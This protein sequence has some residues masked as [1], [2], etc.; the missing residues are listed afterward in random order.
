LIILGGVF[1]LAVYDWKLL[2]EIFSLLFTVSGIGVILYGMRGR[3]LQYQSLSW[4]PAQGTIDISEVETE[5]ATLGTGSQLDSITYYRP[6]IE[7]TYQFEGKSYS[8]KRVITVN[9][10]WPLKETEEIISR[11]PVGASVTVWV[12]PGRPQMAVLEKGTLGHEKRYVATFIIGAAFLLFGIAGWIAIP[13]L[14]R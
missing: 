5:T 14:S 9:I 6:R 4:M 8:S 12:N 3:S 10:N 11:Y 1:W 2:I 13:V 7:Y